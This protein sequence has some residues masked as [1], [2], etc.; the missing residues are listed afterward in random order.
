MVPSPVPLAL[1]EMD[2]FGM[3]VPLKALLATIDRANKI[4]PAPLP[5]TETMITGPDRSRNHMIVVR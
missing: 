3:L 2:P 1:P 4:H 5:D